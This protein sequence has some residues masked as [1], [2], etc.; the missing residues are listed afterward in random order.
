MQLAVM[1]PQQQA[2]E[3]IAVRPWKLG[4]TDGNNVVIR[5]CVGHLPKP[6]LGHWQGI[7]YGKEQE[8]AG[9]ILSSLIPCR[10]MIKRFWGYLNYCRSLFF[11]EIYGPIGRSRIHDDDFALAN[12]LLYLQFA[13]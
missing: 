7:L 1:T 9:S 8:V 5:E 4:T 6:L 11:R 13:Q 3:Q 10:S 12:T 2:I